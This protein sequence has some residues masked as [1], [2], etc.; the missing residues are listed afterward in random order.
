MHLVYT[1]IPEWPPLAWLAC[2]RAGDP[3]V[4]VRHGPRVE[5]NADWFAEAVWADRYRDAAFDRTD[6]VFGSGGR[7]RDGTLTFVSAGTTVDRLHLLQRGAETW[8]SNSLPCLL[9]AVEGVP[10][11]TY[12]AYFDIFK[13]IVGGIRRY[14]REI[15]TSAGPA[16]L[17][18]FDNLLWDGQTIQEVEKPDPRRDFSSFEK[19][20][21]FLQSTLQLLTENLSAAERRFPFRW[22]GT[23]SSG[24]DSLTTAVLARPLGLDEAINF[25]EARG[26]GT[27]S[28]QAVASLLGVTLSPIARDA[29]RDSPSPE[30][31]FIASDAKGEDVFLRGAEAK[32]AGRALLTGH[33]GGRAWDKNIKGLSEEIQ[34]GDQSGLSVTEFRLWAGFLHCP[35]AF[36]GTR[37]IRDLY[38]LNRSPEMR[39]W[40]LGGRYNRPIARRII[41]SAGIP[42]GTF[43]V[44][45]RAG[46]VLFFRRDSFLSP[47][48]LKDFTCWL[49]DQSDEW[50]KRGL[51]PPLLEPGRRTLVQRGAAVA[52]GMFQLL[53]RATLHRVHLFDAVGRRLANV[54]NR[55]PLFRYL[56]PWAIDRAKQRYTATRPETGSRP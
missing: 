21:D 44:H 29:W 18:Y 17:V 36:L 48:S 5:V 40:D 28:G 54:A 45:K 26:G 42:R 6:L 10:D 7:L 11:P 22:L 24:Y 56:F 52:A 12:P 30:V 46:S 33:W 31:P 16:R 1:P 50:R 19:Y 53:D 37:Q 23:I 43:A 38:A 2:C 47:S 13:S 25:T 14:Q 41:E 4:P 15:P 51:V 55:E 8:V 34:R 39:P 3:M 20:R 32:L 27:D 35:I 9:A 49:R